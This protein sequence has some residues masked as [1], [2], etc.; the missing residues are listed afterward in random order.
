[1][2]FLYL[3]SFLFLGEIALVF[4]LWLLGGVGGDVVMLLGMVV[5]V[6]F[7]EMVW[8]VTFVFGSFTSADRKKKKMRMNVSF[9]N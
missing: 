5:D 1:M 8:F 9:I 2:F 6:F 4:S 7:A 3:F